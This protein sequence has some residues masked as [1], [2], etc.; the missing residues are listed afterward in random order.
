M[1]LF[2]ELNDDGKFPAF[3]AELTAKAAGTDI[4]DAIDFSFVPLPGDPTIS[5]ENK[6]RW[7]YAILFDKVHTT[8]GRN[9]LYKYRLTKDGRRVLCWDLG[10]GMMQHFP[11]SPVQSLVW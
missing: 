7:L 4:A 11:K 10:I 1:N 8:E 5:F 3:Y 9:I 6:V 2:P